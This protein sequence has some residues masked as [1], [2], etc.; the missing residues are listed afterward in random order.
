MHL[1]VVGYKNFLIFPSS[2]ASTPYEPLGE[3]SPT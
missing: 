1:Q 3:T 2:N